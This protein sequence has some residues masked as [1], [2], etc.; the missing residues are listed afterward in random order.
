MTLDRTT[1]RELRKLSGDAQRL[2]EEQRDV[3]GHARD[4]VREASKSAGSF[5]KREVLP[6]AQSTY[7]DTV[8]PLLARVSAKAAPAKKSR[9]ALGYV[10]MAIGALAIAAISYATWQTLREDEDLWVSDETE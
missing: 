8:I 10:L 3:L 9:G 4:V 1:R 6:R 2:W 7:R 5:A